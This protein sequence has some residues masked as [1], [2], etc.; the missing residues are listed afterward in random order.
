MRASFSFLVGCWLGSA[1]WTGASGP[2]HAAASAQTVGRIRGTVVVERAGGLEPV[3]GASARIKHSDNRAWEVIT[4]EDGRFEITGLPLGLYDVSARKA[5]Y[6]PTPLGAAIYGQAGR[7]VSLTEDA[8]TAELL[9]RLFRG[10]VISGQVTEMTGVPAVGVTMS[11]QPA[12]AHDPVTTDDRGYYRFFGI[13]PGEYAIVA[14]PSQSRSAWATEMLLEGAIGPAFAGLARGQ[15]P[16]EPLRSVR[17]SYAPVFYP[18]T[19]SASEATRILLEEGGEKS[20]VDFLLVLASVFRVDGSLV[21]REPQYQPSQAT[22]YLFPT[23]QPTVGLPI[24]AVVTSAR[25]F[26][27]SNLPPGQYQ[28]RAFAKAISTQAPGKN[29]TEAI[30]LWGETDLN[31]TA[32]ADNV[33]I[34][35]R[36]GFTIRGVATISP[37]A[38]TDLILGSRLTLM[39]SDV[40][41]QID[42]PFRN[43]SAIGSDRS[44]QFDNVPPG[45]YHLGID[46]SRL[47]LASVV[48]GNQDV[49]DTGFVVD[50]DISPASGMTVLLREER[51]ALEGRLIVSADSLRTPYQIILFPTNRALWQRTTRL[52]STRPAADGSYAFRNVPAGDY[53]LAVL[54]DVTSSWKDTAFLNAV[55]SQAARVSIPDAG[56]IR[57]DLNGR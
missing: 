4:D 40:T 33:T 35:L 7:P 37:D 26:S 25:S 1:V 24:R 41:S 14:T 5:P 19:V 8:S 56:S 23:K 18:S 2:Y 44:F 11:L 36:R 3:P 49:R 39:T 50:R 31:L 12:V 34:E 38:Q 55:A 29:A 45:H 10:A 13:P 28:L 20:G 30:S 47:W 17:A 51:T 15:L 57:L 27:I 16:S 32:D 21:S 48:L 6:L 52:L 53:H 42:A 54:S 46:G 43:T 9:I 22:V